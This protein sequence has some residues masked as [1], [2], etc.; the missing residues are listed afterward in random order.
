MVLQFL[1]KQIK[2]KQ[3]L[4]I[5]HSKTIRKKLKVCCVID[6]IQNK[7]LIWLYFKSHQ[8]LMIDLFP[9]SYCYVG[10]N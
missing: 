6:H 8:F 1:E 9:H 10:N 4:Q 5:Q 7:E 2:T 3:N